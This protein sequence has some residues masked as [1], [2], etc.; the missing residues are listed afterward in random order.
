MPTV[1]GCNVTP[2]KSTRLHRPDEIELRAEGTVGD[3]RFL[4]VRDDG[5]RLSG[6][7]KAAL[8]PLL[9][10]WD[11]DEERLSIRFPDGA[12]VNGSAAPTG[13]PFAVELFDRTVTARWVDPVF[14]EAIRERVD[15]TI[16]LARV[17]DGEYAGG[18]HRVS[19]TS[20]ASIAA[21]GERLGDPGLDGRRFRMLLELD[22]CEPFEEDAWRGTRIRVGEAVIRVGDGMPRCVMTT[23]GPDTGEPDA[24]VL[25]ALAAFR[26]AGTELLFGVYGDVE[27]PGV[28]R[29]GDAVEVLSD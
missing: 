4:F 11:R 19:I 21:V 14:T 24:L 29:L 18:M 9:A 13:D 15:D 5:S 22:G 20:N 26:K 16:G 6:I 3:R 7:S 10:S 25:D 1:S 23:L 28:I 17:A 8:M 2:V 27:Q 12:T